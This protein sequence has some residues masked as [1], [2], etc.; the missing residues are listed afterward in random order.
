MKAIKKMKKM[1]ALLCA[2][3]IC[4]SGVGAMDVF[5]AETVQRGQ[6]QKE[7]L[8]AIYMEATVYD[9]EYERNLRELMDVYGLTKKDQDEVLKLEKARIMSSSIVPYGFPTNP[10][11]GDVYESEIRI[12][13]DSIGGGRTD[14]VKTLIKHGVCAA[15]AVY[16]AGE[17]EAH[18]SEL[19]NVRGVYIR[20]RYTYGITND[21]VLGWTP[22]WTTWGTY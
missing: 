5:A 11:E 10:N 19:Y 1:I 17:I 4:I 16:I 18:Q 22:G 12:P 7:E 9:L 14:I 13:I 21:G 20:I 6:I 8:A 15:V 3:C 2:F